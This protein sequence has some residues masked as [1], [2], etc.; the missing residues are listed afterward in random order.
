MVCGGGGAAPYM[1]T[2]LVAPVKSKEFIFFFCVRGLLMA[3]ESIT[4]VGKE[5]GE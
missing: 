2:G 5:G 1:A 4:V 3:R